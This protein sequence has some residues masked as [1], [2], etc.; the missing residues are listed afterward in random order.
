M[1]WKRNRELHLDIMVSLEQWLLSNWFPVFADCKDDSDISQRLNLKV[2]YIA[3]EK[4]DPYV[5]AELRS[6]DERDFCGLIRVN[7]ELQGK[8]FAYLHEIMHYLYDVGMGN[9]V[10]T[11]QVFT[12][13][14]KGHTENEHEQRI[15][16]LTAAAIIP[17]VKLEKKLKEYDESRPKMDEIKF[18]NDCCREYGQPRD[19]VIRRIQEVRRIRRSKS[20]I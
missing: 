17:Y 10:G 19:A 2:H 4:L 11:G 9:R 14:I 16:Y 6:S 15:N 7:S 5:E 1:F 20:K 12:R 3:P 18:V 13:K 8:R